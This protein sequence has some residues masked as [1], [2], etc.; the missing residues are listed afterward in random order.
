[1]SYTRQVVVLAVLCVM[2][3]ITGCSAGGGSAPLAVPA[4]DAVPADP[5]G[6]DEGSGIPAGT[7][8]AALAW[9]APTTN[10]DGTALTGLAG[11]KLHY[12]LAPGSYAKTVNVGTSTSYTLSGLASGTYY[13]AVTAYN[14]AG[15]ESGHSNE[16]KKTL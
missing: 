16:V 2:F 6:N 9:D 1:M 13:I 8:A 4:P 14:K 10:A 15:A 12:G 3:I 5:A 7:R 11:Y